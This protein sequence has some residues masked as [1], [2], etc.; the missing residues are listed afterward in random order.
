MSAFL[1]GYWGM[2]VVQAFLHSALSAALVGSSLLAWNVRDPSVKQRFRLIVIFVP[3]LAFPLY[4][5]I[6]PDRGSVYF[7]LDALLDSSSSASPRWCS[8][9]RNSCPS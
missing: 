8:F 4:Q 9:F 5:A 1:S 2:Y 3:L 7:R 6:S